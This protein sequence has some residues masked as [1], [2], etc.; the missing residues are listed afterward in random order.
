MP[1]LTTSR[2]H[3]LPATTYSPQPHTPC[4]YLL[5]TP[6]DCPQAVVQL[7]RTFLVARSDPV[8][9]VSRSTS[10]LEAVAASLPFSGRTRRDEIDAALLTAVGNLIQSIEGSLAVGSPATASRSRRILQSAEPF[11]ASATPVATAAATANS[12]AAPASGGQRRRRLSSHHNNA[13]AAGQRAS[14]VVNMV[15]SAALA[16]MQP[17][18]RPLE[19]TSP[20][21]SLAVQRIAAAGSRACVSWIRTRDQRQLD[22]N[23][24]SASAGSG[25]E[26]CVSWN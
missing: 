25:P 11:S 14:R 24:R 1:L 6:T 8:E 26:I 20:G 16:R 15:G 17:G 13:V 10:L 23:Q 19:R 3:L 2:H 4:C 7:S 12:I 9:H 5:P 18:Q 22:T 21:L